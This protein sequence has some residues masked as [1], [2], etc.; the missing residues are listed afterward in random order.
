MTAPPSGPGPDLHA[1]LELAR[2]LRGAAGRRAQAHWRRAARAKSALAAKAVRREA[3]EALAARRA[4]SGLV[5]AALARAVEGGSGDGAAGEGLQAALATW[6]ADEGEAVLGFASLQALR[7][8]HAAARR[9][10]AEE[11][12]R[13]LDELSRLGSSERAESLQGV[14]RALRA[15]EESATFALGLWRETRELAARSGYSSQNFAYGSTPLASWHAV[16][17]SAPLAD[18]AA[19]CRAAGRDYV[20]WGSSIGWLLFYG[21]LGLGLRAVGYEILEC[22]AAIAVETARV[23][24]VE[25]VEVHREDMLE[26]DV[27]GAGIVVLTSQVR[28][29]SREE[30]AAGPCPRAGSAVGRCDGRAAAS[31]GPSSLSERVSPPFP[32]FPA[33]P[34]YPTTPTPTADRSG[35][36]WDPELA[37]QAAAKLARELPSGAVVVD[38]VPNATLRRFLG[39]PGLVVEAPV[40]WNDR[41]KFFVYTRA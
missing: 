4:I 38:Y 9:R 25:N 28:V 18:A 40:S 27:S 1:G 30:A 37:E 13:A 22:L 7:E 36:C 26:S 21:A 31:L 3:E 15:A 16:F 8:E 29:P 5:H 35:Q 24:K 41:Q 2:V 17:G 39:E 34:K 12:R 19:R 20:V 11:E 33:R 23:G 6:L 32:P 10:D 14:L